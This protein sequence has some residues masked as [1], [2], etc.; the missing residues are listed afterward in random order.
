MSQKVFLQCSQRRCPCAARRGMTL[1]EM[2][3]AMALSLIIILAVT[4]VFR[5]VGDNVLASRAVTEMSGQLRATSDQLRRDLSQ[6]TVPVRPWTDATTGQGYFEIYEGPFWDLGLGPN[7]ASAPP[8]RRS[9][10]STRVPFPG[11]PKPVSAIFDDV[12]MF[13]AISQNEPFV[14]QV[15]GTLT[16]GLGGKVI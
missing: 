11:S 16:T 7:A 9:T 6:L 5:L 3:V 14:G 13:T 12:L 8:I 1:V 15:L 2:L 10:R 4:Q